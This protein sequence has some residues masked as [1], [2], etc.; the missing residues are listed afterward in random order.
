MVYQIAAPKFKMGSKVI[1][2]SYSSPY[3]GHIGVIDSE[4]LKDTFRFWYMVKFESNGMTVVG[5]FAEEQLGE[6]GD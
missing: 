5:R 1:V 3:K 4:P 2:N 6:V